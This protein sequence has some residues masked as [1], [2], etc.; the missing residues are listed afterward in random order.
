MALK[1]GMSCPAVYTVLTLLAFNVYG[2]GDQPC[3][4]DAREGRIPSDA[5]VLFDGTGLSEWTSHE[6]GPSGRG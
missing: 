5:F 1:P 4:V 3:I 6:G 2:E